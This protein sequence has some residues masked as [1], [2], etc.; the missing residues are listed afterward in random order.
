MEQ[1]LPKSCRTHF[2]D[3]STLH[4]FTLSVSPDE[5]FWSGGR[6]QFRINVPEEYNIVVCLLLFKRVYFYDFSKFLDFFYFQFFHNLFR[7]SSAGAV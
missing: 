2:D 4:V 6:F 1:N 3:P 5:G 7:W